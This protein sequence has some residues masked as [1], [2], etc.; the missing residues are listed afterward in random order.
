MGVG[1]L[2][3]YFANKQEARKSLRK[4]TRLGFRRAALV[5]KDMDGGG[6]TTDPFLWRRA[7]GVTLAACL[8]GG[9]AGLAALFLQWTQLFPGW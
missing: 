9:C 8:F 1:T 2:I 7:L 6:H 5:H 4:L 3:G